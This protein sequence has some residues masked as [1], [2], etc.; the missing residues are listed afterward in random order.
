MHA[1]TDTGKLLHAHASGL[2]WIRL[3]LVLIFV[4]FASAKITPYEAN[5]IQPFVAN[6]P[7]LSWL[8]A[9]GVRGAS[10]VVGTIELLAGLLIAIG[11]WK[12]ASTAALAGATLSCVVYVTTLSFLLTTP[13]VFAP[14]A[15]TYGMPIPSAEIGQFLLKDIVLLAASVAL[16]LDSRAR[17]LRD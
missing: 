9:F 15:Q 6:S 4:L 10:L 11:F 7:L 17:R 3:A 16:L 8:N 14:V 5:G 12:P 13:G 2:F 1:E